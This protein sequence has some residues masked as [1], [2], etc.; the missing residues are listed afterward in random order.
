MSEAVARLLEDPRLFTARDLARTTT[1]ATGHAALDAQLPGGGWPLGAV[2]E[3]LPERPGIGEL[4]LLLPTLAQLSA[5]G[6][7]VALVSPPYRACA[8]GWARGGV[9]LEH[10]LLVEAPRATDA[11]WAA[12]QILRSTA[13]GAVLLWQDAIG[14]PELRRLQVAAGQGAALAFVFRP[15]AAARAPSSAA[16]RLALGADARIDILKSRGG[17][18]RTLHLKNTIHAVAMPVPA[19]PAARSAG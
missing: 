6:R 19:A 14:A 3:I 18:P 4:A 1:L 17:R 2:T 11:Q 8:P 9:R 12:E 7:G 15:P 16:L 13:F 10:L 5:Q